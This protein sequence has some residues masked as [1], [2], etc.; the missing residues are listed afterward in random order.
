MEGEM[1]EVVEGAGAV[2]AE[3][4]LCGVQRL[5]KVSFA[6]QTSTWTMRITIIQ[7]YV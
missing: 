5:T 4:D 7:F 3:L 6:T 2:V 1:G